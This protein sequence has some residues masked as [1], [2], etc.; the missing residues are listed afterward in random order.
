[1]GRG[2]T[3][4]HLVSLPP[5]EPSPEQRRRLLRSF[6][7]LVTATHFPPGQRPKVPPS[8]TAGQRVSDHS[9]ED[10]ASTLMGRG[11]EVPASRLLGI[12]WAILVVNTDTESLA[13]GLCT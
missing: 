9:G 12:Y 7:S 8:R 1:M 4:G 6:Y 11:R 2:G 3:L 5:P 10:G 13:E